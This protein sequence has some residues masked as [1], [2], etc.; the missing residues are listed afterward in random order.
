MNT[1]PNRFWS[2]VDK[3][4]G[5]DVCWPWTACRLKRW[6]YG[7]FGYLG[8]IVYA[9][10][11]ALALSGTEVPIDAIVL[12][13]CDNPPCCNPKHLHL[14]THIANMRERTARGR[15]RLMRGELNGRAR[16]SA[17]QVIK[18]R[19]RLDAGESQNGLGREFGVDGETIRSIASGK[20]W[21]WLSFG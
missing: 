15:D 9:H 6:G 16:L 13:S 7:Q 21:G 17:A 8:R 4:G 18:I 3:S 12:H 1:D 5:P 14:G 2:K 20:N 11:H 10:R 19:A